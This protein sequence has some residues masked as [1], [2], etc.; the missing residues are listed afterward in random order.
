MAGCIS[1]L[2]DKTWNVVI[3]KNLSILSKLTL[4]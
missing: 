1:F 2:D 4:G 3:D